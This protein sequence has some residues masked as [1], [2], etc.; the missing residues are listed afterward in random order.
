MEWIEA[1]VEGHIGYISLKRKE[2]ANALSQAML[3]EFM[4]QLKEW[5]FNKEIRAVIITGDGEK[6]FCAGADLRERKEMTEK[7]V[8]QA[9]ASIRE[10]V[11]LIH[12][13]PV[14]VIAAINGAA[15]GGGLELALACDIRIAAVNAKVGLSETTLGIIPGAGGT[16]RLAREIGLQRAKQLIFTGDTLTADQ[17]YEWGLLLKVVPFNQ[18]MQEAT[19]LAGKIAQ[20]GPIA[21]KQAK[22]A[23]NHGTE[24]DLVTGLAIEKNSYEVVIPTKDRLE[25]LQAFK[26]KRK[27]QYKGE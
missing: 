15:I 3:R 10:T 27:P 16:Q 24:V 1:K 6:V 5:S 19:E 8:H 9:V 20:N 22:F 11:N 2:A 18:L 26:E 17:A 4:T 13:F 12:D 25:G 14:P 7:E 23:I 21:V